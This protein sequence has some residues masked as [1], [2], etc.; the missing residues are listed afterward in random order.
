VGKNKTCAIKTLKQAEASTIFAKDH[1][2]YKALNL[3]D[4]QDLADDEM[5]EAATAFY[6]KMRK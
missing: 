6:N 3:P 2:K 5:L 1:I 4:H